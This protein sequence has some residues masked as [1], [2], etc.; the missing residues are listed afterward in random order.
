MYLSD[1]ISL[2]YNKIM[3]MIANLGKI[4]K[5]AMT[6]NTNKQYIKRYKESLTDL[7]EIEIRIMLYDKLLILYAYCMFM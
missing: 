3:I 5:A 1:K 4:Q 6:T 7:K 2:S